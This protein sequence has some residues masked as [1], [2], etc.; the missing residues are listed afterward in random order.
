MTTHSPLI[1]QREPAMV[2][3][4]VNA[5]IALGVTFG[6]DLSVEQVGA[7]LAATAA[8]LGLIVRSKVSPVVN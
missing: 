5:V 1:F 3:A 4:A 8:V 7:I 2:M 6:L